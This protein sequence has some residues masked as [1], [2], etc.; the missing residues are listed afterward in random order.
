MIIVLIYTLLGSL[1]GFSEKDYLIMLTSSPTL[2]WSGIRYLDLS[3]M[4]RWFSLEQ[5]SMMTGILVGCSARMEA[6]S[7]TRLAEKKKDALPPTQSIDRS[8]TRTPNLPNDRRSLKLLF[9]I[10]LDRGIRNQKFGFSQVRMDSV[11][12]DRVKK[13]SS[14]SHFFSLETQQQ[15][16]SQLVSFDRSQLTDQDSFFD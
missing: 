15:L 8:I 4:G 13:W 12:R 16:I 11:K 9:C 6:T 10:L 14:I 2:T 3:R 1:C 7:L 5:R